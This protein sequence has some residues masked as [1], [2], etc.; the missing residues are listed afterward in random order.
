MPYLLLAVAAIWWVWSLVVFVNLLAAPALPG[1]I[2][3]D[4]NRATAAT[5]PSVS[6]VVA[7]RNEAARIEQGVRGLMAQRGLDLEITIVDD[8]ST[9]ATP[10][11]SRPAWRPS[12]PALRVV[13]VDSLPAG[14]LG[15]CHAMSLG[16]A[17]ARGQW[18]LL[19]RCRY[20]HVGRFRRLARTGEDALSERA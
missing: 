5:L 2:E 16:A 14:W 9:D 7:A 15:K 18:L 10:Q 20:S 13:R 6:I 8:R 4:P 19:Y 3:H 1:R 11:I 12:L 17:A